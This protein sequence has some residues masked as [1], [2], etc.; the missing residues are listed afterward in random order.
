MQSLMPLVLILVILQLDSE[1]KQYLV[2]YI[3]PEL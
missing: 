3:L 1:S 2:G